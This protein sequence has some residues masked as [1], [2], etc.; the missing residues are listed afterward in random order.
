VL[1]L[2]VEPL[3]LGRFYTDAEDKEKR[4][5]IQVIV[6]FISREEALRNRN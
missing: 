6:S 3:F 4:W 2:Q 5:A 1:R